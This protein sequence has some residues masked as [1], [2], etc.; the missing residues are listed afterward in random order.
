MGVTF[1]IDSPELMPDLVGRL[2]ASGC[3]TSA[4]G[5]RA[6]RVAHMRAVDAREEWHELRF[7]LRAWQARHGVEA[8]LRPARAPAGSTSWDYGVAARSSGFSIN[9]CS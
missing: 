8:T 3:L 6:C 9:P 4:V 5:E 7:F 2:S 1:E